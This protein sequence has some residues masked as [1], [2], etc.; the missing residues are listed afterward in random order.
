MSECTFP[1]FI[2]IS[3]HTLC[4]FIL[5]KLECVLNSLSALILSLS[6]IQNLSKARFT[7][8]LFES[9]SKVY[10]CQW[11]LGYRPGVATRE[12]REKLKWLDSVIIPNFWRRYMIGRRLMFKRR[13]SN[14]DP[15]FRMFQIELFPA[16]LVGSKPIKSRCCRCCYG[17]KDVAELCRC[18]WDHSHIEAYENA[19]L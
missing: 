14:R 16:I 18:R 6:F 4:C 9:L 10:F 2:S 15:F 1:S 11:W 13:T 19:I 7:L 3:F 8:N 12:R 5:V 17:H